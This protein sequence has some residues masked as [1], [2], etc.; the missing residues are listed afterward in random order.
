MASQ[1]K[2]PSMS[3]RIFKLGLPVETVSVYLLCCGI[4][5]A[6]KTIST[7]NILN[8]W[9]STEET[10]SKAIETLMERNIMRRVLSD[11]QGNDVFKLM[12]P[13]EWRQL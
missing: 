2:T 8:I 13:T 3:Q 6:D 9:N 12:D 4:V 11:R 1:I 10:L 5:D 7:K